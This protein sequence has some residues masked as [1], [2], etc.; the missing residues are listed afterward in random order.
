MLF[1]VLHIFIT[2]WVEKNTF[3]GQNLENELSCTSQTTVNIL[4]TKAIEYKG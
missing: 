3:E 2:I 4:V 1:P